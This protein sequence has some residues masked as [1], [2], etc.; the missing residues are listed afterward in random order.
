MEENAF[1]QLLCNAFVGRAVRRVESPVIAEGAAAEQSVAGVAV[2][3]RETCVYREFLKTIAE[4][5][6]KVIGEAIVRPVV[7][8]RVNCHRSL[9]KKVNV[10][11]K[12]KVESFSLNTDNIEQMQET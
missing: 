7:A 1:V 8:P 5:T 6:A 9:I 12:V 4:R 11:V 3:A 2:G 10:N